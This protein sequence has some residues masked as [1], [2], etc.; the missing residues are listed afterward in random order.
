MFCAVF[1]DSISKSGRSEIN[2]EDV[3]A[4]HED[5]NVA[6]RVPRHKILAFVHAN[7]PPQYGDVKL[8]CDGLCALSVQRKVSELSVR[9][10]EE[11]KP[12][13]KK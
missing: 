7:P 13:S 6:V 2:Q 11:L 5:S 3:E 1:H 10:V 12:A 8:G 9:R 4:V